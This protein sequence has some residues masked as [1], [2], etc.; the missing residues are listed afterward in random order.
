MPPLIAESDDDAWNV[1]LAKNRRAIAKT[2]AGRKS[3][4]TPLATKI[5]LEDTDGCGSP[6]PSADVRTSDDVIAF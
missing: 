1:L 3:K 2:S 6:L 4:Q 5:L